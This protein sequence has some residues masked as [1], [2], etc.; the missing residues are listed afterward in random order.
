MK[1]LNWFLFTL[2]F[3]TAV[4]SSFGCIC[5][6]VPDDAKEAKSR[7]QAV[8]A[9][10]VIAFEKEGDNGLFTFKVER[11]WKG[12]TEK[13][14]VLT[15]LMYGSSCNNGLK[16][17]Q[18]YIIFASYQH[19]DLLRFPEGKYLSLDKNGKPRPVIDTC[20]LSTNLANE[21]RSKQVLKKIGKGRLIN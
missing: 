6:I 10:E 5:T 17:G 16:V 3:L 13:Q 8:F 1:K 11:V 15:D 12:V 9:G 2:F 18:R 21:Q 14:L 20:S 7:A 19:F 4:T